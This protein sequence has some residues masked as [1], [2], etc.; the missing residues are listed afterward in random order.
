VDAVWTIALA[1]VAALAVLVLAVCRRRASRWSAPGRLSRGG[2]DRPTAQRGQ[3][4]GAG[5][6]RGAVRFLASTVVRT[7]LVGLACV[8]TTVAVGLLANHVGEFYSTWGDATADM[9]HALG[10]GRVLAR[11]LSGGGLFS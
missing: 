10:L 7:A 8:L 11:L 2:Q 6:I 1:W 9:S 4:S 5:P 3:S